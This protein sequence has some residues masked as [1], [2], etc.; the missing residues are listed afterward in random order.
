MGNPEIG[1]K[2]RALAVPQLEVH[3]FEGVVYVLGEPEEGA[4]HKVL[5]PVVLGHAPGDDEVHIGSPEMVDGGPVPAL[6]VGGEPSRGEVAVEGGVGRHDEGGLV[7]VGAGLGL[8]L[9]VQ[10]HQPLCEQSRM[11]I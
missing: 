7:V 1:N 11:A 9:V 8:H 6:G 10:G 3:A 2:T 5:G 4:V